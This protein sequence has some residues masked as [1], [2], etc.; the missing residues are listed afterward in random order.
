MRANFTSEDIQNEAASLGIESILTP[1]IL[2]NTR[3]MSF[4][5][6]ESIMTSGEPVEFVSVLLCGLA[7]ICSVSEDGRQ[8]TVDTVGP[9]QLLGDIECLKRTSALHNVVAE[10]EVKLLSFAIEDVKSHLLNEPI[11]YRL[12]CDN[13]IEKLY[14]TSGNYA[15]LLKYDT[16]QLLIH[17]MLENC[18]K[19]GRIL[20]K[21]KD[22][23]ELC[24]VTQRH[25][26]RLVSELMAEGF[27]TRESQR[28]LKII[29]RAAISQYISPE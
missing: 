6:G 17:Y 10:T 20:C 2:C 27:I 1:T 7:R 12:I 21:Y 5:R 16:K 19:N 15:K 4:Q 24:G 23:A 14:H 11:F 18:D 22:L 26:S 13:L 9:N 28:R 29:D 3:I 25:I 8:V